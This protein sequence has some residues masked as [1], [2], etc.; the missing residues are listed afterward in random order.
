MT[1]EG[2]RSTRSEKCLSFGP[3]SERP[4]CASTAQRVLARA[5][6]HKEGNKINE[7]D[8]FFGTP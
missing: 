7:A 5:E 8:L 2:N 1:W 6:Q 3:Q 4:G